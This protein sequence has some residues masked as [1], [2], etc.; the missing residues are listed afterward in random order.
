MKLNRPYICNTVD[1]VFSGFEHSFPLQKVK[2][3]K[4]INYL[5][6]TS[7]EYWVLYE[8]WMGDGYRHVVFYS[9]DNAGDSEG[10]A[11]L[12]QSWSKSSEV[13]LIDERQKVNTE[14]LFE[15][16]E[17]LGISYTANH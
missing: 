14:F 3:G 16:I 4:C 17:P 12:V 1:E 13:I 10:V 15:A 2:S 11:E 8:F 5:A 9:S 7:D 6:I